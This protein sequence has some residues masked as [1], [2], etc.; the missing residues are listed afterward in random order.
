MHWL[1]AISF[2]E[3][4]F[5]PIPPD[6]MILPMGLA[7]R[8]KVWKIVFVATLFSVLGGIFGYLLG[9][10]AFDSIGKGILSFYGAMDHYATFQEWFN[11]YGLIIIVVAGLTPIPY[12]VITISAGVFQFPILPFILLSILSRGIRFAIEGVILWFFADRA[13]VI[14]EKHF[15]KLTILGTILLVGGFV[16]V[17]WVLGSQH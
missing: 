2:M 3:S 7:N 11:T 13:K 15:E 8:S 14:I 9:T 10:F 4:S 16:V 5:F 6:L 1:A 17:K 12:K